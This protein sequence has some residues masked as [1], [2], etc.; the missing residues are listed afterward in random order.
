V[1]ARLAA[2]T[3]D[4]GDAVTFQANGRTIEFPGYLRAYVE[5]ADDPDAELEDREAILPELAEGD[6]VD[7]R[8]LVP[9]G[10]TTQPPA[11]YTEA[12]LVKELEERGIGRPS[13]FASVIDTLL[14]RDYVWKKGSA[15]VPSWTAFAKQ[16]LLERHFPHL[17]DYEFTATMEEA[18]DTIARGEAEAEKWLHAF[19]F[20]NGQA[21]LKDLIDDEHLAT[22]DP[23][24]VNA[25]HIGHDAQGREIIVRVWNNGASV[26]RGDDK[27]PVPVD[28]PPDELTI[29]LAEEL[30]ERGAA[31]PRVLGDDPESGLPV[32]ALTGRYGPFVQL[33]EMEDGSKDKPKRASILSTMQPDTVTLG[34]A[35]ALLA[36]PRVVGADGD[37]TEITALNG[38]YGPYLKKGTDSRSLDSEEQLFTVTLEQA[39]AIFAQPKRRR[40]GSAKPPIA[41]LGSHPES[42]AAVRV[43]DGRFGPYVTDGAINA[44]VPRGVE[45]ASIDLEQAVELLREREARGPAKKKSSKR[46]GPP[47]TTK[48]VVK[49]GTSKAAKRAKKKPA[50]VP[51]GPVGATE[52]EPDGNL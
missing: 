25:V 17:I 45:P 40:G 47:K 44:T 22:I 18:L 48:R 39:E 9:A 41:E 13:T 49:K 7:C 6:S 28:L 26:V 23:A 8:E 34:E 2:V 5:G 12:S 21:G 19:W 46:S 33:G 24:D 35:L 51:S 37:G 32:L 16:Q 31:G 43:L 29:A 15:L 14:R 38:R 3:T 50:P 10:H 4:S 27:G 20:G 11:R 30:L 42:G 36:L 1:S 52:E